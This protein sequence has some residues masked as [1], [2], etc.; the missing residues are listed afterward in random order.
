MKLLSVIIPVY[1]SE[2]NLPHTYTALSETLTAYSHEFD[3]ELIFVND[4]SPDNSITYLKQLQKD[5]AKHVVVINFTR[6]FGQVPA[7]L[8]GLA[9]AKGDCAVNISADLQDPPEIIYELFKAWNNGEHK[10]VIGERKTRKDAWLREVCSKF[11]YKMM[12]KFALSNLHGAFDFF[13]IDRVMINIL[14]STNERNPFIQGLL[15]WPGYKPVFVPYVRQKR[16][17]GKSAW[18]LSK[19]I[20]YFIDGFVAYSFFPIRLITFAGLSFF[21]LSI[22]LSILLVVQRIFFGTQL[23]G[24]SS[25]MIAVIML[26]GVQMAMIGIVGEY[27]WRNFDQTRNRPLFIIEEIFEDKK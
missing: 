14:N 16:E 24:W 26:G 27:L 6:N 9:Q 18:S 21:L 8:A 25:I 7:I 20:K 22:F 10:L 4:G 23:T 5:D 13:L 1:K 11:F 2:L 12:Q 17:V 3:Y 15:L 19:L